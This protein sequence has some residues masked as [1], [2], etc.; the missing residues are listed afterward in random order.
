VPDE[1]VIKGPDNKESYLLGE[2]TD[3]AV[4]KPQSLV[5][6]CLAPCSG[7]RHR[8]LLHQSKRSSERA[9]KGC[10][11][12]AAVCSASYSYSKT[13]TVFGTAKPCNPQG[14]QRLM[15]YY[16]CRM[17]CGLVALESPML[18]TTPSTHLL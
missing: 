1:T 9:R 4:Q 12:A 13:V 18:H 11:A 6:L 8:S 5:T 2:Q 17:A 14:S 15:G 3:G 10:R 7:A 16:D